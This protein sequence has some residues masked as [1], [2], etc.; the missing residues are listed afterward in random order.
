MSVK[1]SFSTIMSFVVVVFALIQV[2]CWDEALLSELDTNQLEIRFKGTYSSDGSEVWDIPDNSIFRDDS[3]DDYSYNS[4]YLYP[5]YYKID[6]ASMRL[7]DDKSGGSK[8]SNFRQAYS[9]PLNTD[10]SK[11][12]DFFN[13]TGLVLQNDD[14]EPGKEY[15]RLR[16][17]IRKMLFDSAVR[18]YCSDDT[19]ALYGTGEEEEVVFHEE[20]VT[21][22]DFNQLMVNTKYDSMRENYLDINRVFPVDVPIDGKLV[23]SN[24]I[25]RT[26]LELR[27]V[28]K[29]NIKLYEYNGSDSDSMP[30]VT[31]YF[32]FS[33]SVRDVRSGETDMGGNL[34]AIARSYV[35]GKTGNIVS[36]SITSGGAGYVV[37]VVA[38][39]DIST[40]LI[41]NNLR[42]TCIVN[43]DIPQ[44]P[45]RYSNTIS[46]ILDYAMKYEN[47]KFLWNSFIGSCLYEDLDGNGQVDNDD[48]M[49]AFANEWNAYDGEESDTQAA[50]FAKEFRIP[51]V[52]T[53]LSSDSNFILKDMSPGVYD[54]YRLYWTNHNQYGNF[55]DTADLI[56]LNVEVKE[57]EDTVL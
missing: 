10:N 33:D 13:G 51:P 53:Y 44:E 21:G 8:F 30:Y 31:H 52:A 24:K 41:Q 50:G 36:N 46:S 28:V 16:L 20:N 14:V 56:M 42:S 40:Y 11:Q 35:P 32:A 39:S 23:Y 17:Y 19:D 29:N 12:D 5:D 37:A 54:I 34:V 55:P 9:I 18:Y 43:A 45:V 47:Y 2:S 6:I 38:G 25:E 7:S 49:I 27:F 1:H 26:V 48:G 3:I 15:S 22:F 57:G 4:D